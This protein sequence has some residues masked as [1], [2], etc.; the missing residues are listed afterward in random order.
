MRNIF[1]FVLLIIIVLG[2]YLAFNKNNKTSMELKNT[3]QVV[4]ISHATAVIKF[5][6]MAIYTD[7]VGEVKAFEG[8][9]K[10]DIILITDIHG[11]H[12]DVPTLSTVTSRNTT[13]IVPQAVMDKLPEELASKAKV[14]KNDEVVE[15]KGFTITAIPMYNLPESKDA[16]HPKGRGNGYVVEKYGHRVYVAGDTSGT[17]EMRALKN[18]DI[19]LIPMNLPYTMGVDEA[20]D[21]VLAF[22][23]KEV[24]PYHYKGQDGLSDIEKFKILINVS[25]PNILVTLLDWY[26]NQ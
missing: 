12:F 22:K 6:D 4:P 3:P 21:A 2:T 11:D 17:V 10:A 25:D 23:P 24:I 18:I 8:Q 16:F 5:G 15:E 26:P 14:L 20:A 9:P 7:P 13:L 19:A 1:V